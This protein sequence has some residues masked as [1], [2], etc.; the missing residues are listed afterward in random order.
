[1]NAYRVDLP[2]SQESIKTLRAGDA[3]LLYGVA[4]TAGEAA[5][6]RILEL[7]AA[8]ES[9]PFDLFGA[10]VYYAE[11]FSTGDG[12]GQPAPSTPV[13]PYTPRLIRKGLTAMVGRGRRIDGVKKAM[14]NHA[15]Y[16]AYSVAQELV[17]V[18]YIANTEM[19]AFADLK[20]EA[21]RRIYLEGLPAV[22]AVDACGGDVY[23]QL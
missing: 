11:P 23:V 8:G 2:L 20:A 15:V 22:V 19:A 3:V 17:G 9:L 10:S 18:S 21:V 5:H 13:D 4:Y 16:F 14:R 7:L 1:M 6:K 12:V